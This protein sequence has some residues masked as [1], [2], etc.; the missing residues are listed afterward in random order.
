MSGGGIAGTVIG[1]CAGVGLLAALGFLAY[2]RRQAKNTAQPFNNYDSSPES[3]DERVAF[4][5]AQKH[6]Y[7]PSELDSRAASPGGYPPPPFYAAAEK[8]A[9]GYSNWGHVAELADNSAIPM[10]ELPAS[11]LDRRY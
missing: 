6:G 1:A 2:R 3:Q 11:P 9:G 5:P 10:A 4:A 7:F 8:E